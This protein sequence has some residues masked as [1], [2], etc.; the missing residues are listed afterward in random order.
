MPLWFPAPMPRAGWRLLLKVLGVMLLGWVMTGWVERLDREAS[1]RVHLRQVESRVDAAAERLGQRVAALVARTEALA[2]A[3]E[4]AGGPVEAHFQRLAEGHFGATPHLVSVTWSDGMAVRLVHPVEG[5]DAVLGMD[6]TMHPQLIDGVRRAVQRAATQVTGPVSLVQSGRPGLVVRTPRFDV[7]PDGGRGELRGL[8]SV[9]VGLDG[10]LCESGLAACEPPGEEAPS[11]FDRGAAVGRLGFDF[12]LRGADGLGGDGEVFWGDVRRFRQAHIARQVPVA[13]GHWVLAA[14]PTEALP[15]D[16]VRRGLIRGIGA[17]FTLWL[18]LW[19]LRRAG[20]RRPLALTLGRWLPGWAR[21]PTPFRV[22]VRNFVFGVLLT[23]L[24]GISAVTGYFSTQNARQASEQM[25]QVLTEEMSAKLRDEVQEVLEQARRT[26]AQVQAQARSDLWSRLGPQESLQ[27]LWVLLR[28]APDLSLVAVAAP[29]GRYLAASR[30]PL[31]DDKALRLMQADAARGEALQAHRVDDAGQRRSR[32]PEGTAPFDARLRPW[33]QA[34]LAADGLVWYPAQPYGLDDPA[35]AYHAL[36]MGAAAPLVDG[37]GR[38]LGVVGADVALSGLASLLREQSART[39]GLA[40][41]ADAQ[42]RLLASSSAVAAAAVSG[43]AWSLQR[44]LLIES[45]DPVLRAVGAVMAPSTVGDGR[46]V[47]E[48]EGQRHR[49][50]WRRL[51]LPQGP[52]LR[53][54]VVLPEAQF[55]DIATRMGRTS[56][57]LALATLVFSVGF[58]LLATD[59]VARPLVRLSA[60][61]ARLAEGRRAELPPRPGPLREV[62]ALYEAM[63]DMAQRIQRHRDELEQQVRDRTE[64]LQRANEQLARL[65]VTDSLTGLS[66]RRHFDER[67][68]VEWSRARRQGTPLALLMIDVDFFK[69]YNDRYGHPAGDDCLARVAG[70]LHGHARRGGDFVARYGGEEFV[71]IA[72]DTPMDKAL[73]FAQD[74]CRVVSAPRWPHEASPL[75][76]VTVSV[77]VAVCVPDADGSAEGLLRR[78]DAALYR[79]KKNGRNRVERA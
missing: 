75:G 70:V 6:Y 27:Q 50:E 41:V 78:A 7:A 72:P 40:F 2:A 77:G 8:L 5:N 74:L 23:L 79:A 36:G 31:G 10:L 16:E 56:A 67:L 15:E 21:S 47:V 69:P 26:V 17:G 52:A 42:G 60:A 4:T 65:S 33:F 63:G 13:G 38:W 3:L 48:V 43:P 19:V 25:A 76:H 71:M 18:V 64:A 58:A 59:W 51:P 57:Y 14:Q 53:V 73:A 55:G 12:A 32:L 1:E 68:S 62:A 24:L 39:G 45:D 28:H 34:A 29:D 66:N 61:A 20:R 22:G 37:Q 11:A 46:A 54:G 9:A 44:P 30:P 49:V 35:G